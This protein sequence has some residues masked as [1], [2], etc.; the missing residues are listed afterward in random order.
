MTSCE[1]VTVA[2]VEVLA[3][4][5]NREEVPPRGDQEVE[6]TKESH[7]E[8]KR[9]SSLCNDSETIKTVL[10]CPALVFCIEMVR[11]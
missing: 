7:W 6:L 3:M 10:T 8:Q 4:P 9:V 11:V 1:S 2:P 5:E